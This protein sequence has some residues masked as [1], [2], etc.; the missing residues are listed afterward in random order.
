MRISDQSRQ[1][2]QVFNLAVEVGGYTNTF[3]AQFFE[4]AKALTLKPHSHACGKW[5]HVTPIDPPTALK[6]LLFIICNIPPSLVERL[7]AVMLLNKKASLLFPERLSN[8]Q[9]L[10]GAIR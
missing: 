1:R 3:S 4:M 5:G 8:F 10:F 6:I 7:N 9:T 2:G